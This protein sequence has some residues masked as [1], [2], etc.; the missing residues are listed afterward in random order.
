M[1]TH[2]GTSH[3]TSDDTKAV[4]VEY[5]QRSPYLMDIQLEAF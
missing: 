4:Q 5:V 1:V 2:D 3:A